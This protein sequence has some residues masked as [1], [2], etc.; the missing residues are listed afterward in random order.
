MKNWL[1][2]ILVLAAG[3]VPTFWICVAIPVVV[4]SYLEESPHGDHGWALFGVL[5][6]GGV[7]IL[8]YSPFLIGFGLVLGRRIP[9]LS[10]KTHLATGL[11]GGLVSGVLLNFLPFSP[12]T[13]LQVFGS[14]GYPVVIGALGG[15]ALHLLRRRD[16]PDDESALAREVALPQSSHD[17]RSVPDRRR[18]G[19][20]KRG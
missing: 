9:E 13:A 15:G 18:P 6:L 10:L 16:R 7:A 14:L 3:Y 20:G 2:R 11:V 12:R 8:T 17:H 5:I 19:Q 1:L 4:G